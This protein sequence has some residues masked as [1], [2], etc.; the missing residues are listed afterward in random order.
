MKFLTY[1]VWEK[2]LLVARRLKELK[3][4]ELLLGSVSWNSPETARLG[5]KAQ[6]WAMDIC[7]VWN[8]STLILVQRVKKLSNISC[9]TLCLGCILL[10]FI[11]YCYYRDW[12]WRTEHKWRTNISAWGLN[13]AFVLTSS[14][15]LFIFILNV[16]PD[17]TLNNWMHFNNTIADQHVRGSK[18][19]KRIEALT[20]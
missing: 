19:Y 1:K 18:R 3:S 17:C 7:C 5:V 12:N 6:L 9:T 20:Q 2:T 14:H 15:G 11:N 8:W 16:N 13:F 4:S 10:L